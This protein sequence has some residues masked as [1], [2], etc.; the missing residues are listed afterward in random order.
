MNISYF[1]IMQHRTGYQL[2]Y[3]I[4]MYFVYYAW[5]WA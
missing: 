2:D 5:R 3:Y 4:A 1:K